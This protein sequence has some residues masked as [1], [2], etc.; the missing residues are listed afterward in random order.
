[1]GWGPAPPRGRHDPLQPNRMPNNGR[2]G[3]T[4]LLDL[5][6]VERRPV[7]PP[8]DEQLA[9]DLA[10]LR[11]VA[12]DAGLGHLAEGRDHG[13]IFGIHRVLHFVKTPR[14]RPGFAAACSGLRRCCGLE[15]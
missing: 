14:G 8:D 11:C 3:L 1:M 6:Y 10:Q 13:D 4:G 9:E 15:G 5:E 7:R 2:L 12:A